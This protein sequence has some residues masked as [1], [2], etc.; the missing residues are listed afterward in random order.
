MSSDGEH[1]QPDSD[2]DPK[3]IRRIKSLVAKAEIEQATQ[4]QAQTGKIRN[5][6]A[7]LE[8]ELARVNAEMQVVKR[9]NVEL[10]LQVV[11]VHT[12]TEHAEVILIHLL[13]EWASF[14]RTTSHAWLP[15]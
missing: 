10:R 7:Q 9:E 8:T 6:H 5:K 3:T 11:H 14:T 15:V 13:L 12:L 2:S 4:A 1:L